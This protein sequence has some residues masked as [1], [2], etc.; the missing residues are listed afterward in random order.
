MPAQLAPATPSER[1]RVRYAAGDGTRTLQSTAALVIGRD[2]SC[3]L[4]LDG[5]AVESQHAELYRVG[6]LWWV[7]DLGSSDG[8]YLNEECIEVAPVVG[9]SALRLGADGPRL[10]L[11]PDAE[12]AADSAP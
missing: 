10:W 4:R 5:L 6:E 12:V 1:I 9:L 8:T 3:D 7:R 11:H 2:D